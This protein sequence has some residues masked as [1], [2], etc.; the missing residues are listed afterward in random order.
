MTQRDEAW[1]AALEKLTEDGQFKISDLDFTE[2]Q[3]HTVRRALK[4]MEEL[5]WL[6][7]VNERGRIWYAGE[8]AELLL[9]LSEDAELLESES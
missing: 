5:G 1:S 8:K 6:K 7:R 3:R 9:N 2:G 4:E